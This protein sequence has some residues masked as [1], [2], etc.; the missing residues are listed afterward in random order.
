[1]KTVIEIAE[2]VRRGELKAVEIL[3]Q[4]L[5]KIASRN[6]ELNA[7]VV[8]DPDLARQAADT[9]DA[10]VARGEDPGL[11]AGVPFGVKDL[12]DCAGLPTSHGSL[13]YKDRPPVTE[14]SPHVAR[15]RAAGAV[16]VGKTAAPEFGTVAFTHTKAWGTTRNPWN[17]ERTPG[18]SSGGS[19][20]AVAAGIIP[21]GTASDGGGSTRIPAAFSGLVGMKP[22]HGRIPHPPA[23]TAQTSVYGA[24]TTTVAD[25]A[26]HLD[27]VSGPD[28]RDR[29]SLPSPTLNYEDAIESFD[30]RGLKAA[31]SL[32]LGF[33]AVD[34][35]V[36]ELT[37]AAA[38][39]LASAAELDLIDRPIELTDPLKTWMSINAVDGWLSLEE[40][41]WPD[42]AGE[43]MGFVRRGYELTEDMTIKQF[44]RRM[45]YRHRLENEVAAIFA[46][47]DVLLTPST[48][49][50][51]FPAAGPM[52]IEINGREVPAGMAVPFTMLANLCWNPAISLPAGVN[53]EGLPVG[54]QVIARR[55]RDEVP[56]RLGRIFEQVRPW[57]RFAPVAS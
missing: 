51:A 42:R 10:A 7:F 36:A 9:V 41:M 6:E 5:D 49:V 16:P 11:L 26:R 25:S 57:P 46:D 38:R 50:P 44:A 28:D 18:G 35:E 2:A 40:D 37:E 32:D 45:R 27:V 29:L 20:A 3:D 13:L 14:D 54:L 53:S 43:L 21:F 34:P 31:W 1:V 47:V 4:V 55:H 19:A 39:E 33:A 23:S 30:V 12:E 52:P 56:L 15:L 8:L 24:L 17:T 22:S 48:A